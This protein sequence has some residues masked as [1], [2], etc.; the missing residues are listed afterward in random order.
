MPVLYGGSA[1][2][3]GSLLKL[4]IRIMALDVGPLS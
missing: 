1:V 3:K 4:G 2:P